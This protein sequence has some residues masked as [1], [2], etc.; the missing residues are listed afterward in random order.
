MLQEER[1]QA[2]VKKRDLLDKKL[3]QHEKSAKI[4]RHASITADTRFV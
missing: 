1:H 4:V 3:T 2:M